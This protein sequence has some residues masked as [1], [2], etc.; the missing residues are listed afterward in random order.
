MLYCYTNPKKYQLLLMPQ[1]KSR[2]NSLRN[3]QAHLLGHQQHITKRHSLDSRHPSR[4]SHSHKHS[5]LLEN[6]EEMLPVPKNNN[7]KALAGKKGKQGVEDNVRAKYYWRG[8]TSGHHK[9]ES[10]GKGSK[11]RGVWS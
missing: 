3:S 2:G 11:S 1:P 6:A 7:S 8:K 10:R 5:S 4:P 9:K